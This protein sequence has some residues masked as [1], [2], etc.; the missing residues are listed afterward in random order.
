MNED[1]KLFLSNVKRN[2]YNTREKIANLFISRKLFVTHPIHFINFKLNS[3]SSTIFFIMSQTDETTDEKSFFSIVEKN[4]QYKKRKDFG[5][6][7]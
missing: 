6:I 7:Y 5:F 1:E 2:I 4:I 3:S